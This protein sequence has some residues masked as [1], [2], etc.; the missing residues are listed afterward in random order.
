MEESSD[1]EKRLVSWLDEIK[2]DATE[3]Y[4]MGDLFDFWFE[5]KYVVPKGFVRF[6]GKIAEISDSGLNFPPYWELKHG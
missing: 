2:A 5:Y 3:I 4:L 6:L 1:R